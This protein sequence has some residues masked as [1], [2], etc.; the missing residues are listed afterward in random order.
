MINNID[1]NIKDDIA[2]V[3]NSHLDYVDGR[4][5]NLLATYLG[6][7]IIDKYDYGYT[8]DLILYYCIDSLENSIKV[9]NFINNGY[10]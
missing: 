2:K 1:R 8:L 4:K 6:L 7:E 3:I 9:L 5:V 10:K